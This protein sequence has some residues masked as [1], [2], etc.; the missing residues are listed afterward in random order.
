M[1][2]T[3]DILVDAGVALAVVLVVGAIGAFLFL[4]W[5]DRRW[6]W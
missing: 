6:P 4:R 5:G 2:A 1:T 3:Q